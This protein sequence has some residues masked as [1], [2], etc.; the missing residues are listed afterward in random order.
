[1]SKNL[2]ATT[3]IILFVHFVSAQS[4]RFG[5]TGG[6]VAATMYQKVVGVK[7]TGDYRFGATVGILLDV[8]MLKN[9]SFQPGLNYVQ[10]GTK[11]KLV[12]GNQ[13]GELKTHLHYL[14]MPLNVVFRIPWKNGKLILGGGPAVGL[15]ISGKRLHDIANSRGE[16]KI[17]FGDSRTDDMIGTDFG[18]NGRIGYEFTNSFFIAADYSYGINRLFIGGDK[19][20]K[21]YNRYI[22]IRLGYLIG[23]KK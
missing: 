22:A 3:I 20:D 14:E 16:E 7:K 6:P 12:E 23:A 18:L 15:A 4:T 10:K 9:G 21:L 13:Q 1:M 17:E 11:D 5:I 8:P 19:K 2:F